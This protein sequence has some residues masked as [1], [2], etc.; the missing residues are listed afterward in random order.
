MPQEPVNEEV[1][2]PA[3]D[4][5]FVQLAEELGIDL[6]SPEHKKIAETVARKRAQRYNL[7]QERKT[8]K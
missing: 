8:Q 2:I 7:A 6:D 5:I 1:S 3:M 4:P